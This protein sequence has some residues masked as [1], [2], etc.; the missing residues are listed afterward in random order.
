[1]SNGNPNLGPECQKEIE[2]REARHAMEMTLLRSQLESSQLRL[3]TKVRA[4]QRAEAILQD[5]LTTLYPHLYAQALGARMNTVEAG[6]YFY[7][8]YLYGDDPK[9]LF[10]LCEARQQAEVERARS[11]PSSP[12][13]VVEQGVELSGDAVKFLFVLGRTVLA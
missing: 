5:Y 3:A 1:M 9:E 13:V 12:P 7:Q 6:E 8:H 11:A 4:L 10:G 2:R